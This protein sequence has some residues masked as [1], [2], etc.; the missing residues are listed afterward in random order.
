[1]TGKLEE[2]IKE[3]KANGKERKFLESLELAI[4][5]KDLDLSNPK[6]RINDEVVLPKGRGREYKVAI[7][8]S[9]EMRQKVKA[10]IDISYGPEDL[11]KFADNKK[12]FKK[13]VNQVEYFIAESNL[14]ATIGKSL[15]QVLGPRGK[16]PR[17]VPP[18]QDPS[19][20]IGVLKRTVRVRTRD[21]KTFHVRVGT[22]AM[23]EED[24]GAN[25]REVFK[26]IIGK[27]EKGSSNIDSIYIKTTMG[28][29]VKLDLGDL[30]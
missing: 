24:V 22:R 11:S 17:P 13:I 20:M 18:G 4:N 27:L 19:S 26:R 6:N 16:I 28:K 3:A 9:E 8:A 7:F 14:M 15:G 2:K 12:D 1:M 25:I 30:N 23:P 10:T 5:L 29:A 21:K